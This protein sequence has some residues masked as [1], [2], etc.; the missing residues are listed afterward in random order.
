ML[1]LYLIPW[2]FGVN[3]TIHHMTGKSAGAGETGIIK[4]KSLFYILLYNAK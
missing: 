1:I 2:G 4:A 3:I